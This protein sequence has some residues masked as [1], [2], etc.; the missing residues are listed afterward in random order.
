[1]ASPHILIIPVMVLAAWL[2]SPV[3][4]QDDAWTAPPEELRKT[5]PLKGDQESIRNGR[6]LFFH[7][8]TP[9]HGERGRGDGPVSIRLMTEPPDLTAIAGKKQDG[10]LAWK[11]ATGRNPMPKWGN[12]LSETEIWDLVNFIQQ[13]QPE[14]E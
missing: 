14:K 6:R 8:C 3:T 13:L 5:N 4:A 1:M 10:E 7:L 2:C 9:C 11:I 12:K